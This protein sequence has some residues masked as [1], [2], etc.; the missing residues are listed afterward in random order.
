MIGALKKKDR[1]ER[2]GPI[3]SLSILIL[4]NN[5]PRT[6]ISIIR[7]TASSESSHMLYDVIVFVPPRKIYEEYSSIALF[8]SPTNGTYFMT[9]S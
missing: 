5:S 7:G 8:E 4:V 6:T 3:F 9:T 2:T 1:Y